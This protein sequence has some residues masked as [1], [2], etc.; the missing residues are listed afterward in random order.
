[1]RDVSGRD[2][3]S[4]RAK[5]D[6]SHQRKMRINLGSREETDEG[7]GVLEKFPFVFSLPVGK[8]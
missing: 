7:E 2:R 1:M 3:A 8:L 5:A 4:E 6:F